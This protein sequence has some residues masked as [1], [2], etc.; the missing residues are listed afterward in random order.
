[1]ALISRLVSPPPPPVPGPLGVI[2]NWES[3]VKH[4]DMAASAV[5]PAGTEWAGA[6]NESEQGNVLRSGVWTIDFDK[7]EAKS[8]PLNHGTAPSFVPSL[9]WADD[10]TVRVLRNDSGNPA[11]TTRSDIVYIDAQTGKIIRT[12]KLDTPVAAILAWP[13]KSSVFLAELAGG[14]PTRIA[15]LSQTGKIIGKEASLD[16]LGGRLGDKA[17]LSPDGNEYIVS[18]VED[19]SGGKVSYYMGSTKDPALKRIFGT[20]DLPGTIAGMWVGPA[21]VL[22]VCSERDKFQTMV[23]N[24]ASAQPKIAEIAKVQPKPDIKKSWP[25]APDKMMFASYTGGYSYDP[26]SG[27]TGRLFD[28]SNLGRMDEYWR[29]QV[30]DG[31]LYPRAD[32]DYTSVSVTSG[33]VDIRVIKKDGTKGSDLL[34]RHP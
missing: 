17:A 9:S 28:F 2:P 11:A 30:R 16:L 24:P 27:K 10:N 23:Y 14:K 4:G 1:M 34:P 21:G 15:V 22:V 29:A 5:N 33:V 3:T 31:R 6:W 19:R 8:N 25:D 26:A 13:A 12:D 18:V 20:D 7:V 32:G